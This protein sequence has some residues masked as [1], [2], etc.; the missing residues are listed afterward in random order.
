M[1]RL[2]GK[3]ARP[4]LRGP[5]RSNAPG[6]LDE[7]YFSIV[8]RKVLTPNDFADLAEL[9]QRLLGFQHR[10]QQTAGPFNW[11]YTRADLDRLLQRLDDQA[12]L[13]AAA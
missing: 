9:K 6:L 5:R 13:G 8:Q 11:R 10:Y 7:I 2:P 4:V 1:S 12:H 3:R